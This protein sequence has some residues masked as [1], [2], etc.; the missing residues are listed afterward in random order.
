[1]SNAKRNQLVDLMK[2]QM[3]LHVAGNIAISRKQ[4]GLIIVDV[5]RGFCAPGGGNLAPPSL[6]PSINRMVTAVATI[7]RSFSAERLPVFV[8]QEEHVPGKLEYPYPPHC[9]RGS[10]E[11]ELMPEIAFLKQ[12]RKTVT[13]KKS[14]I[15]GYVAAENGNGNSIVDWV[16]YNQIED[17]VLVGIC[18][19]IC[20]LQV[21]HP[22]L[23]AR[24]LD[25]MPVLKNVIAYLPGCGTYDLP[26]ETAVAVGLPEYM[27]HPRAPTEHMG[28]YLMQMSGVLLA[29]DIDF[30]K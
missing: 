5:V 16:N 26:K 13:L 18:T 28:L 14:C 2:D 12:Y 9:E 23:S 15:S 22:L 21:A 30:S 3:P 11:E 8:L 24:N 29:R 25:T 27:A 19:D 1:M 20:V 7:A 6:D 4:S 10:G 17:L